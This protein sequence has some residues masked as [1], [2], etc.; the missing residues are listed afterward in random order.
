MDYYERALYNHILSTQ[1]PV[2]GGFVYFT[3]MRSGHY[4]VYSQPQTS[5]WCCVGS[6]MEN[7][8]KY[9]E[10]IYAHKGNQLY[11]NLFIPSTLNWDNVNIEQ[12]TDFPNEE[13]TNIIVTP[14]KGKKNFEL[15]VRVPGWAKQ[16]ELILMVND[17]PQNATVKDGYVSI[18]RT[19]EKGDKVKLSLP[20][21]L[22][23]E[24]LPV[25]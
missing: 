24:V 14:K 25:S 10:M 21:S 17:K 12:K 13:G 6:G 11:V 2:Q 15:L 19:W 16:G 23:V 3:P 9:G 5:F 22:H 18:Q 7:H 8:A 1:D 20:M 4:R